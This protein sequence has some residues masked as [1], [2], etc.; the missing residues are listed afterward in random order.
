MG[1]GLFF[2]NECPGLANLVDTER[3]GATKRP[4]TELTEGDS[5]LVSPFSILRDEWYIWTGTDR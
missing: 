5:Y 3:R 1:L 4:A 2:F